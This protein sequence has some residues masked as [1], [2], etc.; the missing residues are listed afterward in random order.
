MRVFC[1][2]KPSICSEIGQKSTISTINFPQ[3][4]I[5]NTKEFCHQTMEF[6]NN[7]NGISRSLHNFD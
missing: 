2:V 6:I 4:N 1:R 7:R 3:K 5:K